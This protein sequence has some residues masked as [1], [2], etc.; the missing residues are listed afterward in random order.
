M[1]PEALGRVIADLREQIVA[2]IAD[3]A[4]L[5]HLLT[6]LEEAHDKYAVEP[7]SNVIERIRSPWPSDEVFGAVESMTWRLVL[8]PANTPHGLARFITSDNPAFYFDAYGVGRP[9]SELAIPLASDLALLGSWQGSPGATVGVRAKSA[10][11]KE[12]N[13]ES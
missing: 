1:V 7:P 12:V 4:R 9:E 2:A 8:P 3:P 10:L 13:A 5:A 11:V 6:Q